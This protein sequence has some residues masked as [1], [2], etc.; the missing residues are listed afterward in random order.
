MLIILL[1][2]VII[3][4]LYLTRKPP[5]KK[6][7]M[8]QDIFLKKTPIPKI[9]WRTTNKKDY[10]NDI[11]QISKGFVIKDFDDKDCINFLIENYGEDYVN[12]FN[13]LNV[14]AHKADF[15]RYAALYKYGGV[16][17]D[18]KTIP[19]VNLKYITDKLDSEEKYSWATVRQFDKIGIYNGI[20]ITPPKN[21][22]IYKSLIDIYNNVKIINEGHYHYNV[23]KLMGYIT[24]EY[25]QYE[26]KSENFKPSKLESQNSILYLY[27][28]NCSS[29]KESKECNIE[30]RKNFKGVLDRLGLCCNAEGFDKDLFIIRDPKY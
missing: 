3:L 26:I 5:I 30:A 15:W 20:I 22:I 27:I 23:R 16:Y 2:L 9:I 12:V 8:S 25:P 7:P 10:T 11:S 24:E 18:I 21:P 6:T 1:I 19:I 4:S 17:L 14:G 28:E 29:Y 13:K